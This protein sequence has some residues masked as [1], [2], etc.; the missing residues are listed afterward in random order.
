MTIKAFER[1]RKLIIDLGDEG[2][3]D[4]I[5]VTVK[6]INSKQGAALQAIHAGIAF[7]QAGDPE[8]HAEL[9]GKL[10]V[11]EENWP[12]IDEELRWKEAE[13]VVNA[14]FFWNV[15]GGGIDLVNTVLNEALGGYP[16]ALSTLMERNGL[17]E[18][19][20]LLTTLLNSDEAAATP[21]PEGTS[22]TS[23]QPGSK[24]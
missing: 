4:F 16:K 21:A 9:M 12:L 24:N 18:A 13:A 2:E 5:R 10:A 19:F 7:G 20:G 23:T 1:G 15:Q 11:G 6:P 14:G 3:E 17:S 8:Q 22:D